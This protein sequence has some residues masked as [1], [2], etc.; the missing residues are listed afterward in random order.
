MWRIYVQLKEL[1]GRARAAETRA[2]GRAG[3]ERDWG[4]EPNFGRRDR[5]PVAGS[6]DPI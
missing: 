2:G 4:S 6:A 1:S 3:K 5:V